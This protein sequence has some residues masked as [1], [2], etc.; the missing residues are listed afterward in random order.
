MLEQTLTITN[1]LGLHARAAG[2]LVKHALRY[3]SKINITANAKTVAAKDI[4]DVLLLAASK[5][6]KITLTATGIDETEAINDLSQL[7]N[8]KFGET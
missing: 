3:S 7:I 6:T 4:M 2:K 5:D 8:E 1:K